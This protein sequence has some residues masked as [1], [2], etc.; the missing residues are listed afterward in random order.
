MTAEQFRRDPRAT[1]SL[2]WQEQN[3]EEREEQGAY[4]GD[5]VRL[6]TPAPGTPPPAPR[7]PLAEPPRSLTY[8]RP[9]DQ[10]TD[11]QK[12]LYNQNIKDNDPAVYRLKEA[13]RK[14]ESK[15]GWRYK[16]EQE[17]GHIK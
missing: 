7:R 1:S 5:R 3:M 6:V 8:N 9:Y 11:S 13:Q 15:R 17:G 2:E 14:D 16:F 12:R 4:F 10:L